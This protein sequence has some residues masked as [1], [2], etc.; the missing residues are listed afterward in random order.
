MAGWGERLSAVEPINGVLI[1]STGDAKLR[2]RGALTGKAEDG[3]NDLE[4]KS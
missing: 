1:F 2:A 4:F 3:L